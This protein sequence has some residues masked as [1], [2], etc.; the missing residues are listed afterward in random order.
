MRRV[1]DKTK[2]V[3]VGIMLEMDGVKCE[4]VSWTAYHPPFSCRQVG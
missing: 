4:G 1:S 3:P 2:Q